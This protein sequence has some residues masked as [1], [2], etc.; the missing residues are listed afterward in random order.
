[1]NETSVWLGRTSVGCICLHN[2]AR[3]KKKVTAFHVFQL[4]GSRADHN[5]GEICISTWI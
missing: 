1:M 5:L 3:E 4:I 2:I